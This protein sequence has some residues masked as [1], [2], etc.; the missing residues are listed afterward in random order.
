[1]LRGIE[2][3]QREPMG[4]A[5]AVAH[6]LGRRHP[7][8]RAP[9]GRAGAGVPVLGRLRGRVRRSGEADDTERRPAAERRRRRLGDAR[10]AR[11]LHRRPRAPHG[12]RVPVP[13]A[14]R[15][16]RRDL[17]GG[18]RPEDRRDVRAL[19]QHAGQRVPRLR[20]VV[21]GRAPHRAAVAPDRGA[22]SA[23]H[24]GRPAAPSPTTTPATSVGTTGTST[25][26][27][28]CSAPRACPPPRWNARASDRSA[29]APAARVC[30]WR[31][32]ATRGST[33]RGSPRRR[34][35]APTRSRSRAPTAS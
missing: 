18:R 3:P 28:T 10:P 21:R 33:T 14:G 8:P 11:A 19:L 32:A 31:R 30:G 15:A 27:A 35:R 29:A 16:E 13:D 5:G 24:P 20:G 4:P 7:R 34:A 23:H 6:R 12:P 22:A 17:R 26:P 2:G 9:A 1:M 25:R